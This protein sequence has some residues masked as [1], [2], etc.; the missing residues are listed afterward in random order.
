MDDFSEEKN[1]YKQKYGEAAVEQIKE[2]MTMLIEE[3][4]KPEF[5]GPHEEQPDKVLPKFI[6]IDI[7]IEPEILKNKLI[8]SI[9]LFYPKVDDNDNILT[10][11]ND[12][13]NS[14]FKCD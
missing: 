14:L 7:S 12:Y 2:R 6:N 4:N 11:N 1:Y 9:D 5:F 8:T 13:S 3:L 10:N